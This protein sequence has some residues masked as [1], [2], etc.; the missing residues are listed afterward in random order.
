MAEWAKAGRDKELGK[1]TRMKRLF[2]DITD[3]NEL[4]A[5]YLEEL[6]AI[7]DKLRADREEFVNRQYEQAKQRILSALK[8]E[9]DERPAV[10]R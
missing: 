9:L 10:E 2:D 1:E 7:P 5:R 6:A 8:K 4:N 3:I